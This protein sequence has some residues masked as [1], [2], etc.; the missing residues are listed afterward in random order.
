M[1]AISLRLTAM[2]FQPSSCQDLRQ[3]EMNVLHQGI[4]GGELDFIIREVSGGIVAD[5][6]QQ[7][8]KRGRIFA[9]QFLCHFGQPRNQ[10]ELPDFRDLHS[11]IIA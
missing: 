11:G 10:P 9:G 8:L 5:T 6:D 7:L 3:P 1:A 4:D 2:D